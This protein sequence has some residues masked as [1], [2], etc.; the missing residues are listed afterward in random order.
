VYPRTD[1]INPY[2]WVS[3]GGDL[4]SANMT[5]KQ[6][7]HKGYT[8]SVL[9]NFKQIAPKERLHLFETSQV[10]NKRMKAA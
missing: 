7:Q 10:A 8:F 4:L 9:V 6:V 1:A 5:V 2:F 3:T